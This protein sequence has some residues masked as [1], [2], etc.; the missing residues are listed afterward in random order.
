VAIRGSD[1]VLDLAPFI[2][3]T[4]Q[5]LVASGFT[6]VSRVPEVHPTVT[7]G[8]AASLVR[9]RTAYTTLD[10]L[11]MWL[12]WITVA[13]L[14]LG[15]YL[16]RDH[17]RALLAAGLG[18]AAGMLI[19]AAGLAVARAVLVSGVPSRSAAATAVSFDVL[20]RFLREGLRT[21]LVLG[22]VVALGAFLTGPSV[23]AVRIR[24]A[25][26]HFLDGLR[27]RGVS[28]GLRTGRFGGWVYAYRGALRIAAV[29]LAALVFVFLDRPSGVAVVV[30]AGLLLVGLALIQF[31]A[32]PSTPDTS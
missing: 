23:T 9:A 8:D 31:F 3:A 5:Q 17:R 7:V 26:K 22:L 25:T 27:E 14:A 4:K 24:T 11:A 29:G 18:V 30:I 32:Q 28:A 21:L 13:L 16:A 2:D 15:V 20:F 6:V 19:L 1:V 12:P 10:R